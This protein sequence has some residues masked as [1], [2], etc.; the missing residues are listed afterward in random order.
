MFDGLL[1]EP[2]NEIVMT[3]LFRLAEWHALAKLRMHIE[4]TLQLLDS[5]TTSLGREVRRFRDVTC[6]AFE[7]V[8]LEKERGARARKGRKSKSKLA[9]VSRDATGQPAVPNSTPVPPVHQSS[10]TDGGKKR[11]GLNIST[12]KFHAL[13]DYVRTIRMFGTTDS[14]STQIV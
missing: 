2:H 1:P 4:S 3:L 11:K 5:A 9:S 14:Y 13:G 10:S 6:R 7:T 12:Y 8:E